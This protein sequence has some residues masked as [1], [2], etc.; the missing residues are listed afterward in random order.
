MDLSEVKEKKI[1][2]NMSRAL[3][4]PVLSQ[5]GVWWQPDFTVTPLLC[6]SAAGIPGSRD[7]SITAATDI[8][9]LA[10][11]GLVSYT[12]CSYDGSC[13]RWLPWLM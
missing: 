7:V 10:S 1:A 11:D 2:L 5:C 4:H 13:F 6:T 9:I 12:N 8:L 3:G